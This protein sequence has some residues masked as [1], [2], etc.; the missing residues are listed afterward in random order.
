MDRAF[1]APLWFIK[2]R[3]TIYYVL[4]V[5]EVLLTL[6]FIFMLLG[7]NA[8]SGFVAFLYSVTNIF[9]APFS[10]IFNPFVTGGLVSRSVFDPATLVAMLVYALAGW[11][12][13][14]LLWVKAARDGG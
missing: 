1:K 8:R 11:G 3:N 4:G 7:A 13:V 9:A 6:R 10:G 14:R 2:S 12:L 5:I